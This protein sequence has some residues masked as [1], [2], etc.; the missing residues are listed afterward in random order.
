MLTISFLENERNGSFFT[1]LNSILNTS[2][3]CPWW[4]FESLSVSDGN[5]RSRAQ[6][7]KGEVDGILTSCEAVDSKF[8]RQLMGVLITYNILG[9]ISTVRDEFLS[10]DFG[11]SKS[12]HNWVNQI[13]TKIVN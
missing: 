12:T 3:S 8:I 1:D 5:R 10:M 11:F 4:L 2:K 7:S 13:M 6:K 9:F